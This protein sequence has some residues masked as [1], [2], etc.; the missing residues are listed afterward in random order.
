MNCFLMVPAVAVISFFI[1]YVR[2]SWPVCI[3]ELT[4]SEG[5]QPML[6]SWV[7]VAITICAIAGLVF[8]V[9]P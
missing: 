6:C 1:G 4:G 2:D 5:W 3:G 9:V 8:E 7:F